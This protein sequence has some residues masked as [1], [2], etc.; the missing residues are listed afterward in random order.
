M[1]SK[2]QHTGEPVGA[3]LI[4]RAATSAY[5]IEGAVALLDRGR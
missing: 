2:A 4:W 5:R 1:T 3:G